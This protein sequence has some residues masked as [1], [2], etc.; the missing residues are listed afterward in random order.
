MFYN[1]ILDYGRWTVEVE[2]HKGVIGEKNDF[3]NRELGKFLPEKRMGLSE[4]ET[5][6]ES[7][8]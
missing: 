1:G 7:F 4:L 3:P 5:S 2:K 6:V 8:E